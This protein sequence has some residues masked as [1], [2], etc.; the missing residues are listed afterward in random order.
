MSTEIGE[1]RAG[2]VGVGGGDTDDVGKSGWIEGRVQVVVAHGANQHCPLVPGIVGRR[3]KEGTVGVVP[4]AQ[5]DHPR[6]L[7]AR[8][9]QSQGDVGV[10][11]PAGAVQHLDDQQP[12]VKAHAGDAD[13]VVR[14]RSRNPRRPGAVAKVIGRITVVLD[15]VGAGDELALQIGMA[16]IGTGVNDGDSHTGVAV[17][18][19]PGQGS[20]D[21]LR[22]VLGSIGVEGIIG[23]E[24]GPGDIVR[25]NVGHRRLLLV[26]QQGSL[27]RLTSDPNHLHAN[28]WDH[29]LDDSAMPVMD[30]DLHV[31]PHA[32]LELDQQ[33]VES[34][35]PLKTG[36]AGG[37]RPPVRR[38]GQ[39]PG[40]KQSQQHQAGPGHGYSTAGC[41]RQ[42]P[43]Y[44]SG[45]LHILWVWVAGQT[46]FGTPIV[47]GVLR[48][49]GQYDWPAT[50]NEWKTPHAPRPYHGIAL[51]GR[52]RKVTS[53]ASTR[54][55]VPSARRSSS[56]PSAST[57]SASPSS[58]PADVIT[59]THRPSVSSR[60]AHAS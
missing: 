45:I 22:A 54:T 51:A 16:E 32:F 9:D 31:R 17:G 20:L 5:A 55:G 4:Q 48:V 44:T 23:L 8:L 46:G 58:C 21:A 38:S 3:F 35:R 52:G 10:Q 24:D 28:V 41:L 34:I 12:A 6:P 13:A 50:H 15:P 33:L 27:Q 2:I 36:S 37:R 49:N 1:R 29:L 30:A 19:I 18:Q 14:S 59:C 57:A 42:A 26:R 43:G 39:G 11:G 56:A 40:E 53:P 7:V 60:A 47:L 25:L